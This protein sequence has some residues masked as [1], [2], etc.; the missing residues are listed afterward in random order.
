MKRLLGLLILSATG[1]LAQRAETIPFLGVMLPANETPPITDASSANAI[2][3][4]HVVRDATGA[5]QSGSVDFNIATKFSGAVTVTG[6][7]IHN[8]AAG[9]AGPIVIPT[10]VN[11]TDKSIA[12]DTTGKVN[13]VKQVQFPTTTPALP[14]SVIQD[15]LA[16]PQNYYVN[17]HTTDHP[18]GAMRAQLLPA[19]MTIVMGQMNTKNEVPPVPLTASGI[20]TVVVLRGR[21]TDGSV[22][23]AEAI[24]NLDYTGFDPGTVFTGFHIHNG[25]AGVNGSV[26]INTGIGPG[27]AS[28]PAD[29]TG[30]G[31]LT[32]TVAMSPLDATF[33]TEVGT[34]NSLFATPGNQYINI[35]TTTFGGG[36]MRDQLRTAETAT[37]RVNMLASNETPPIAGLNANAFAAP[38]VAFIRNSDGTVAAGSVIFDVNFRGF[39]ASTTIT[40][41][42]FHS[43]A[44][45]APGP[46]VIDSTVNATGN[47]VVSDTGNGNIYRI[48]NVTTPAGLAALNGIVQ[49]PAGYYIN[50]HTTVNPGGAVREQLGT[51]LGKPAVGGVAATASTLTTVAPGSIISI[52]GTDLSGFDSGLTGFSGI[53]ALST[54]MNGVSVTVGGAKAPLYFVS[55]TQINAQVPFETAAGSQPVVVTT[56]SGASTSFN[57]TVAAVAP[58]VFIV[59]GNGTGAIIKNNDGSLIT[60]SNPAKAGDVLLIYTTGLGQTTPAVQTATLVV[61]PAAAF[62]N[63]APVTVS[64]GG[65]NAAI[66]YSIASPG[67]AG[68]YQ[69]AVTVP[70]GVTGSAKL[71]M[72]AGGAQSNTVNIQVQ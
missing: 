26:I 23:A 60:P 49:N 58:S 12:V 13:I 70:S 44:A 29:A 30:A 40:G 38:T 59:D 66:A 56:P 47:R 21:N 39:P 64:I 19:D 2:I 53:T 22:G 27:A 4:V 54:A 62:N 32:Y 48:V 1:L 33:A 14:N 15:L 63:T 11:G 69:T 52:Y 9:V 31:N 10:D 67:F 68:L 6:L 71:T 72:S 36:V 20:A 37:I 17:I 41:L 16:N 24:F 42:H 28:V 8:A 55:R 61:P 51:A 5:V 65:Q 18:S 35:H 45:G 7:H 25:A 3:W 50:M 46:V 57:V 43:G 34:V